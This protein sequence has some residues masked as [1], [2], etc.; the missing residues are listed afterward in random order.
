MFLLKLKDVLLTENI[1]PF[2]YKSRF[3]HP[4]CYLM[5]GQITAYILETCLYVVSAPNF[6]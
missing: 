2:H 6:F 1:N 4:T 5:A 3:K